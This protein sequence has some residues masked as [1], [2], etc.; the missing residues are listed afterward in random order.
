MVKLVEKPKVNK[1]T[2]IQDSEPVDTDTIEYFGLERRDTRYSVN[3]G[4]EVSNFVGFIYKGNQVLV[5]LPK[6]YVN[7]KN[8]DVELTKPVLGQQ[9]SEL[10]FRVITKRNLVKTDE[11]IGRSGDSALSNYPI[12]S[13][14][15][16]YRYYQRY[17]LYQESEVYSHQNGRGVISWRDTVRKA[18]NVITD[19]RKLVL[20]PLYKREK[21]SKSVFLTSCMTF[22]IQYTLDQFRF[23]IR[24]PFQGGLSINLNMIDHAD[25]VVRRL[26]EIEHKM[27]KDIHKHLINSLINFFENIPPRG[28]D[29]KVKSYNFET[30]WEY[31]VEEYLNQQFSGFKDEKLIFSAARKNIF[32]FDTQVTVDVDKA[33][34]DHRIRLDYFVRI[35]NTQYIFDAKY[36]RNIYGLNYKQLAYSLLL[37]NEADRTVNTLIIPTSGESG[38]TIKPHFELNNAVL[39]GFNEDTKIYIYQLN[40][41]QG[42]Q[43]YVER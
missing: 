11:L 5:S 29:L 2:F 3:R 16:I 19:N 21:R 6:H 40:M 8:S 7:Y 32:K 17:G 9:D 39:S 15:E 10:L 26:R 36:F 37:K 20:L 1:F 12:D 38:Q 33:H 35:N 31:I 13:F 25:Q 18:S 14:Y 23:A 28:F 34:K 4:T 43:L 22:A 30:T 27:F 42:M 41:K 24:L